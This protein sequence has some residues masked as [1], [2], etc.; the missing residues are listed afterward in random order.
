MYEVK[1][2]AFS[3]SGPVMGDANLDGVVD[4]K[5]LSIL[6]SNWGRYGGWE[7][8]DF[9][10]TGS[11]VEADLSLL[12]ANWTGSTAATIPE[13]TALSFFVVVAVRLKCRRPPK[14]PSPV[15]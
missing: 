13:P 6:L 7:Q 12:L 14:S 4:D 8:G 2:Y 5:D 10:S 9:N 1:V 3:D 15:C 11:V